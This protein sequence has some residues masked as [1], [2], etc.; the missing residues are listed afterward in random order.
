MS[1]GE[2]VKAMSNNP[3]VQAPTAGAKDL[4]GQKSASKEKTEAFRKQGAAIRQSMSDDQKALEG[5]KSD[6]VEFIAILG[7]PAKSQSRK[8][9]D[10]YEDSKRPCGFQ[11]K[12]L[13][14]M[15]VPVAPLKPDCVNEL[16]VQTP[17]SEK[18]V[19]AGEV[20]NLNIVET[21][22]FISR[23]EFAGTFKGGGKEVFIYPASSKNAEQP[24]PSLRMTGASI[25]ENMIMVA[26]MVGA[27][28]GK[29]G[30]PKVLPEFEEAFAPLFRSRRV[31]RGGS[32]ASKKSGE[33]TKNTAAAFRQLYGI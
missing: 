10:G 25:K 1:L 13:E 30:T 31:S 7:N 8:V 27:K 11:F 18:P 17:P 4:G 3:S 22:M 26:E 23:N 15:T 12:V 19:K 2:K 9:K 21:A 24:R 6:K 20:V 29:G 28:D 16:D 33:A 32:G 14:D 5:S